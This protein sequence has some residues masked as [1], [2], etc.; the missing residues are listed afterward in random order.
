MHLN[1]DSVNRWYEPGDNGPHVVSGKGRWAALFPSDNLARVTVEKRPGLLLR[2]A[3]GFT[4]GAELLRGHGLGR[5]WA[6]RTARKRAARTV[7]KRDVV[8]FIFVIRRKFF[9]DFSETAVAELQND[10]P[11]RKVFVWLDQINRIP[12]WQ[13]Y[14]W[15]LQLVACP[16]DGAD[17]HVSRRVSVHVVSPVVAFAVSMAYI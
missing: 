5:E 2:Q 13:H 15:K 3:K 17:I 4:M 14:I 16:T 9:N 7:A 1:F 6:R 10:Q 11:S 12:G 8:N